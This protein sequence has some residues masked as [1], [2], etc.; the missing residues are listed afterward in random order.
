VATITRAPEE[1]AHV[2]GRDIAELDGW[3]LPVVELARLL[4]WDGDPR[5]SHEPGKAVILEVGDDTAALVVDEVL[6]EREVVLRSAPRRLAGLSLLLGTSQ[7]EDGTVITVLSPASCVR[8]ALLGHPHDPGEAPE[9]AP[10]SSVLLVEDTVTTREL[11]R[12]ILELAGY[13]VMVATDGA[14]AWQLLQEHQVDVVVSDIDM[15]R[16]DGVTLCRKIR[17]SSRFA[18]L[19]VVLVT[20]LHSD[21]DRQRGLD[22]G[23]DAYLTKTGFDRGELLATLG[24]LL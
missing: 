12:S 9:P 11:E 3:T 13:A 2:D 16:M 23:A 6:A 20:S 21:V 19:P 1:T 17:S 5:P 8:T 4:A 24:R 7:L 14:H 22:A 10:Q 18:D 15:P